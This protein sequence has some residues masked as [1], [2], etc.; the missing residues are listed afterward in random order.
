MPTS[1]RACGLCAVRVVHECHQTS[2]A[3]SFS[4]FVPGDDLSVLTH[5][6]LARIPIATDK[7]HRRALQIGVALR[8][9]HLAP[10]GFMD[11][12]RPRELAADCNLNFEIAS[13][14]RP[15]LEGDDLDARIE[16]HA[17]RKQAAEIKGNSCGRKRRKRR[18]PLFVA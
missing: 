6:H 2:W 12:E 8:F 13:T 5:S 11:V 17:V 1:D 7:S 3:T 9:I 14:I 4:D 15:R 18:S 16:P 10:V